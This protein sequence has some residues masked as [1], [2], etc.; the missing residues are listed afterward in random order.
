MTKHS[1]LLLSAL[2]ILPLSYAEL[3][4]AKPTIHPVAKASSPQKGYTANH[5][6]AQATDGSLETPNWHVPSESRV[7]GTFVFEKPVDLD[8]IR[9]VSANF[10][11]VSL[12]I[13]KGDK[14]SKPSVFTLPSSRNLRFAKTIKDIE[15]V[16]LKVQDKKPFG[17]TLREIEFYKRGISPQNKIIK[18]VFT[19]LSCSKLRADATDAAIAKL[20][21]EL[22]DI[23]KKI[24]S[25]DYADAD[26]RIAQYKAFSTPELA[27]QLLKINPLNPLDNP[28]GIYAKAGDEIY[29]FVGPTRGKNIDLVSNRPL[30]LHTTTYPLEEGI[31]KVKITSN[32]L[33]YISYQ[34]DIT[35]DAKPITVHIP[36]G[37]GQVNGYFDITKHTDADW[38][39]MI[40]DAPAEVFDLVGKESMMILTTKYLQ[41]YS[42]KDISTS[43]KFWDDCVKSVRD[44]IGFDA[45]RP[46]INN[47][48]LGYS[49]E[50]GAHM[51]SGQYGCGYSN[52]GDGYN[53]RNEVIAPN[54]MK[55][56]TA[57]GFGH[58]VGHSHQ[59]VINW[60]SMTESSNNLF[61]QVLLDEVLYSADKNPTATDNENPCKYLLEQAVKGVPFHNMNGWSQWGFAQYSFYLYF[62]KLGINPNFYPELFESL[63]K[64]PLV[65][66]TWK[67]PARAHLNWYIR[68]CEETK[69]DFTED[70]EIFNWFIPLDVKKHQ[71]GDYHYQLTKEMA[72]A[73]KARVKAKNFPKPKYRVAFMHQHGKTITL[74]G[75]SMKG[76]ELNGYWSKFKPTATLPSDVSAKKEGD[77]IKVSK[78]ENAAAF[79]VKTDGKIV[80]YYDR[81]QFS[82]KDIPWNNSS[83]VYAIP[84][85]TSQ[86]YK[87]IYSVK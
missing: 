41:K 34:T 45:Y 54:I 20:P 50:G 15:A 75:K 83:Q 48:M 31:N 44:L 65:D 28:T 84:M 51:F 81:P 32:G 67:N 68:I 27:N 59:A 12:E 38:E 16:R 26:F 61:A 4:P 63:R 47:R 77:L 17:F 9:F 58:E 37:S 22:R 80:G 25:G 66:D 23:A 3:Q 33:L 2:S 1:I 86:P 24:K 39:R 49:T 40:S 42:S 52:G 56:K 29:V 6:I 13:K 87:L 78:G 72:D 62:H 55:G 79:C 85:L 43:V 14:W 8:G 10:G 21:E 73:A 71:Y 11:T 36:E 64:K 35:K 19:D 69:T 57:W 60:P 5:T 18:T 30:T 76:W 82:V 53:L 70:F 46:Q 7:D 74:W